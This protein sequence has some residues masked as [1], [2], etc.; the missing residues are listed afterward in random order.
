MRQRS[1]QRHSWPVTTCCLAP[2]MPQMKLMGHG[3]QPGADDG[4]REGAIKNSLDAAGIA[5]TGG[6]TASRLV[7]DAGSLGTFIGGIGARNLERAGRRTGQQALEM[8]RLMEAQ[9]ASPEQIRAATNRL[10][11][12]GDPLLGGVSKGRDE[13]RRLELSDEGLQSRLGTGYDRVS[14]PEFEAGLSGRA[15]LARRSRRRPSPSRS[16]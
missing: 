7:G 4:S 3:Y 11:E 9:G 14:H 13:M 2:T 15:R 6:F 1:W 12:S 8:A 5:G 10:M 16:I